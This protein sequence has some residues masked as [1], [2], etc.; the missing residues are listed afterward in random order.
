MFI[1]ALNKQA[2]IQGGYIFKIF[3]NHEMRNITIIKKKVKKAHMVD[4]LSNYANASGEI[5]EITGNIISGTENYPKID[6]CNDFMYLSHRQRF[7][8]PGNAGALLLAEGGIY[9]LLVIKNFMFVHGGISNKLITIS[10]IEFLNNFLIKF[11]IN[12][13]IKNDILYNYDF[14]TA[15]IIDE[16][17]LNENSI[18]EDRTFGYLEPDREGNNKTIDIQCNFLEKRMDEI[19]SNLLKYRESYETK[20]ID[21]THPKYYDLFLQRYIKSLKCYIKSNGY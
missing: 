6:V 3:G 13:N 4:S 12:G 11:L 1:N 19:Y 18:V 5:D 14:E 7:F 17:F 21:N 9:L 20:N 15:Q 10:N 16:L 8:L 2:S